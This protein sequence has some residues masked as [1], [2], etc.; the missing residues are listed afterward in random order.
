[1]FGLYLSQLALE[2]KNIVGITAAMPSGTGLDALQK[3]IPDRFID[4][5]IA[6]EHAVLLAGMA[7]Q[8]M[9]PV[10]AIYSTFLRSI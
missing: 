7:T 2:N 5:G 6:E 8:G 1:M 9:H 4:V 10:C 3:T